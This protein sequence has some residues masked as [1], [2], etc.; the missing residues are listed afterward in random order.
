MIHQT[1][2]SLTGRST[3]RLTT[4]TDSAFRIPCPIYVLHQSFLI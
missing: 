4:H 1:V 3:K 2:A